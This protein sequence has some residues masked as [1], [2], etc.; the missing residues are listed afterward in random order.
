MECEKFP[1]CILSH[2]K[3]MLFDYTERLTS[4]IV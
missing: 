4:R 3:I 2:R 1:M